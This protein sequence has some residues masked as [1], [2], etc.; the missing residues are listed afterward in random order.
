MLRT[1]KQKDFILVLIW[2]VEVDMSMIRGFLSPSEHPLK[3]VEGEGWGLELCLL[4]DLLR[5]PRVE[6]ENT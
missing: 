4:K 1:N 3:C 6:L 2:V 5:C